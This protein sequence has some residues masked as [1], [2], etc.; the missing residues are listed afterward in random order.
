M[1]LLVVIANYKVAHLTIDCLRSLAEEIPQLPG[2]HVAVCENGTGDDSAERIQTAIDEGGWNSWCTLTAIS[3]NLGFTGG[4]NVVLQPFLQSDDPPQYVLLLNA[5]TIAH[6]NSLRRLVDF[7]DSNRQ[8]GIAGSRLEYPDGEPQRSAFR[9]PSALSEFE[10][11]ICLGIVNRILDRWIV[12][13]PVPANACER[14]WVGGAC[15]IIR[16][17]VFDEIGLLDQGYY[18]HYEDVD[19]CFNARK[20]GWAVWYVPDSRITHFVGQ[21]T[22][23][24][25]KKPKRFPPYYFGA[26]RRYFLKNYGRVHAALADFGLILGLTIGRLRVLFGKQITTPPFFLYDTIKHSVFFTGF[27]LKDVQNPAL[28]SLGT[29]DFTKHAAP[30]KNTI[31]KQPGVT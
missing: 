4:N 17:E 2:T 25:V 1:R 6:P 14:D 15:M 24:T 9:F 29:S 22:G 20:A 27:R 11:S 16:R 8:I 18:T 30:E 21:S 13:P 10:S 5:D 12:A 3:P 28:I 31:I 26:R 19:F 23:L 7:M